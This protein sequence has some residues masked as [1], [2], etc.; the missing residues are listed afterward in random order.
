MAKRVKA[1]S[2]VAL[3]EPDINITP[4]VDVVLVL[5]IIFMVVTPA[6]AEGDHINLP[7]IVQPDAKPRDMNPIDLALTVN[8]TVLLNK[9][10][11]PRDMLEKKLIEEHARDP[12]KLLML[13]SDGEVPYE[14]VRTTFALAQRLGFRGVALKVLETKPKSSGR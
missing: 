13:K 7:S 3:P 1:I 2:R 5:L 11:I 14:Q 9:V 8:G 6:L 12:K 4:L 10:P